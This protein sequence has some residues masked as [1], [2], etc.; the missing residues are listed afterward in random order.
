LALYC[1]SS[2]VHEPDAVVV[3]AAA[4]PQMK[5]SRVLRVM[6]VYGIVGLAEMKGSW[7][8]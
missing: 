3:P 6:A 5:L 4:V 8:L 1:R 2:A 7:L